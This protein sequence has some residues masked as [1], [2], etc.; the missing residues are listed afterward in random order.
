MER[1]PIILL[2]LITLTAC[3]TADGSARDGHPRQSLSVGDAAPGWGNLEA[4]DGNHYE[5]GDFDAPILAV[6]FACHHCPTVVAY[7]DRMIEL[8]ADYAERGVQ[9][10]AINPNNIFEIDRMKER[11]EEKGYN[12]PYLIDASQ[13]SGHIFGARNTPHVFLFDAERT[14]RYKGSIDNHPRPERADTHY[15]RDAIDALL[16]GEDPPVARTRAIGCTVKYA[17][18]AEYRARF[19]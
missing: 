5:I 15:A 11:V 2:A 19:E 18:S 8:Q 16:E 6:I 12:F 1:I 9:V 13:E 14:L 3:G 7:E 10:V 4:T 17:S